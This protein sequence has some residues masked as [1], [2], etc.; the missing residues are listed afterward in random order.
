MKNIFRKILG[1]FLLV[2]LLLSACGNS[3]G[4]HISQEAQ[5]AT[6]AVRTLVAELN[7]ARRATIAYSN[8]QK[9]IASFTATPTFT[10][11][12]TSTPTITPTFTPSLTPTSTSTSTMTNTPTPTYTITPTRT[13]T[14][15]C[16]QATFVGD[17]TIANGTSF[18]AG[19]N[20]TKTWRVINSGSCSWTTAY[21][22]YFY[23]GNSM[24]AATSIPFTQTIAP[25]GTMDISVSMTAPATSGDYT[26]NWLIKDS[27]GNTFGTGQGGLT[28]LSVRILVSDAPSSSDSN[29]IYDFVSNY[30]SGQWRTNAGYITC[31]TA[32]YDYT[33]GT[34]S[35]TYT[36][37]LENNTSLSEGTLITIPDSSTGGYIQGQYPKILVH[38]GDHFKADLFCTYNK[39]GC[40]VTFEVL[41]EEYGT[42]TATSLGTWGKT[43]DGTKTSIDLDLSSLDGKNVIFYL[44]VSSNGS[45]TD[46]FAQ[47]MGARVTHP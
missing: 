45:S 46:D 35:R 24:S 16:N 23:S 2:G 8:T 29:T 1:A 30:C 20:F 43:Y 3:S 31:P 21:S 22:L 7:I 44:K 37:V 40:S 17:V 25:G 10:S 18:V 12:P 15:I 42:N 38:S 33:N 11:T 4:T 47:W 36:P 39:G 19:D 41:Y 5:A 34:I 14:T 32:T 26:G 9:A 27:S 28:P 6:A 13:S